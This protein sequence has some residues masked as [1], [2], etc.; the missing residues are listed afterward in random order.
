MPNI[1]IE[2]LVSRNHGVR[3]DLNR[4]V[5][6][7]KENVRL[8]DGV[9][10]ELNPSEFLENKVWLMFEKFIGPDSSNPIINHMSI[11]SQGTKISWGSG[12]GES[13]QIDGLFIS[14]SIVFVTESFSGSASGIGEK[15]VDFSQW[16]SALINEARFHRH[17]HDDPPINFKE[18]KFIWLLCTDN[19]PNERQIEQAK[20][21]GINIISS[22]HLDYM[23]NLIKVYGKDH[24]NLAFI[25]LIK[26][27]INKRVPTGKQ[28]KIPA[29]RYKYGT[30]TGISAKYCYS[31]VVKPDDILDLCSVIHRKAGLDLDHS[32]QRF[33]DKSRLNKIKN[34]VDDQSPDKISQFSNNLILCSESLDSSSRTSFKLAPPDFQTDNSLNSG[35][36]GVLNLPSIFGDLHIIDGQHR[37]FGY[38]NADNK[39]KHFINVLIF[40]HNLDLLQ[41]MNVFKD[42]NENQKKLNSNLRWELYE[43]TLDRDNLKQ[44]ISAFFNKYL[45]NEDFALYKRVVLGTASKKDGKG[46]AM[47]SYLNICQEMNGYRRSSHDSPLFKYIS[48][49]FNSNVDINVM[50]LLNGY[51]NA[52]KNSCPDDWSMN[53]HGLILS[54]GNFRGLLR[55]FREILW[56]WDSNSELSSKLENLDNIQEDFSEFLN[57]FTNFVNEIDSTGT[58]EERKQKKTEIKTSILGTAAPAAFASLV[59]EKIRSIPSL[60]TFGENSIY[61]N[62][63]NYK[64]WYQYTMSVLNDVAETNDLEAKDGIFVSKVEEGGQMVSV[65][66]TN[67]THVHKVNRIA[68]ERLKTIPAFH[69]F[70][71]GILILGV[72]DGTWDIE[73]CDDEIDRYGTFDDWKQKI[74]ETIE[75]ASIENQVSFISSID[76]LT[77]KINGKTIVGISVRRKSNNADFKKW[78]LD[79]NDNQFDRYYTRENGRT[80][81]LDHTPTSSEFNMMETSRRSEIES[82]NFKTITQLKNKHIDT[83]LSYEVLY[84]D[85]NRLKF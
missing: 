22:K 70:C 9:E 62:N 49:L 30:G 27:V 20:G 3:A 2:N 44:N 32:Y 54:G 83:G 1:N 59:A 14:K 48:S 47:L 63:L 58:Y 10:R 5:R 73:G 13:Q 34:F 8:V 36:I 64:A 35:K 74:V 12:S 45:L 82:K 19:E 46:P 65:D 52:L 67:N 68:K 16:K 71:G 23:E 24:V 66:L 42:I 39:D 77:Q 50:K 6:E 61:Q 85:G 17:N 79:N 55:V 60:S 40:N 11:S 33:V 38:N 4:R 84:S 78:K 26:D 7:N 80:V 69:N 51:F 75:V 76:F 81:F 41:Q 25:N 21:E 37:L 28:I 56:Y 43:H 31:A 72:K 29:I 53:S 18:K 15:I 57:P